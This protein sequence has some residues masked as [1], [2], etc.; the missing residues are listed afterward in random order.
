MEFYER[1]SG[2]RMHAAYIRP[3]GV[4]F[5]LPVGLLEDITVFIRQFS[6]RIDEMEELLTNNRIWQQRLRNI[7]VVSKRQA[8]SWGFSGVMVRGSG[9]Q[10]D[11]RVSSPYEIYPR[12]EFQAPYAHNGDCFDRYL[13]RIEEMRQSLDIIQDVIKHMPA[14]PIKVDD[15]KMVTPQRDQ[16]KSSMEALIHH[17]K[18]SS[19]GYPVTPSENYTAVEAPKGEFGVYLVS[20]GSSRLHR[21]KI[22]SPGFLHLQGLNFM[23]THHLI[24]DVVTI[25]GTQDIVFGEVDR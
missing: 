11:L 17:F 20:N 1:V 10:H 7:G 16:M 22:K 14:G 25:I 6:S 12:V 19:Q 24:A 9:V 18:L 8:E 23:A 4:A 2:A 21:C 13:I 3:G 5:D 15:Y